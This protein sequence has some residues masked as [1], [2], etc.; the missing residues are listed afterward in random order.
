MARNETEKRGGAR[1]RKIKRRISDRVLKPVESLGRE[2]AF[3]R[4]P[5]RKRIPRSPRRVPT[6]RLRQISFRALVYGSLTVIT[7]FIYNK[8]FAV[9][10]QFATVKLALINTGYAW[11]VLINA[12]PRKHR[13][14]LISST[15]NAEFPITL[16]PRLQR[17]F[18]TC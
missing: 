13:S 10:R 1:R 11:K 18:H 5:R 17:G 2:L 14:A 12:V 6:I 15:G 8:I 9:H 4:D 7:V 16:T 3:F